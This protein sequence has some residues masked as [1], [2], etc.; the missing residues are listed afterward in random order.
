MRLP[1]TEPIADSDAM[2]LLLVALGAALG[3]PI[4]WW[5]D[6]TVQLKWA[7]L[8]PW[9]TFI[10]NVVGSGLLGVLAAVWATNASV[11]ALFGIGLCGSMTTFSSFA[12]ETQRLAMSGAKLVAVANVGLS[13]VVCL[14]AAALGWSLAA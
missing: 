9:G 6:R 10:V 8:F 2:T 11:M 3:A 1:V 7:P 13:L 14:A 12:Y 5:V 4:R